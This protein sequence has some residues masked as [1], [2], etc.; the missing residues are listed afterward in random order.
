MSDGDIL[1]HTKDS[2]WAAYTHSLLSAFVIHYQERI[3]A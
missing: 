3:K 2:D 1:L